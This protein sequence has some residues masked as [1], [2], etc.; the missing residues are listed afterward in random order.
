MYPGAD[1][2]QRLSPVR[3][4]TEELSTRR[5]QTCGRL[6]CWYA[7]ACFDARPYLILSLSFSLQMYEVWSKGKRPYF[8]LP[9]LTGPKTLLQCLEAG[10][11]V[12]LDPTCPMIIRQ[13]ITMCHAYEPRE[14]P[15]MTWLR[16]T[17]RHLETNLDLLDVPET[18]NCLPG[19]GTLT[20]TT[21]HPY[22]ELARNVSG[23]P[24]LL[25]ELVAQGQAQPVR[26]RPPR[27]VLTAADPSTQPRS[28]LRTQSLLSPFS[29]LA[30]MFPPATPTGSLLLSPNPYANP[31]AEVFDDMPSGYP[32]V[33]A[34]TVSTS[35]SRLQLFFDASV[36]TRPMKPLPATSPKSTSSSDDIIEYDLADWSLSNNPSVSDDLSQASSIAIL[37]LSGA[38]SETSSSNASRASSPVVFA[39]PLSQPRPRIPAPSAQAVHGLRAK[40][41]SVKRTSIV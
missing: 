31:Y 30:R 36:L 2:H 33:P 5:A 24:P 8:H 32:P 18:V 22:V 19:P 23:V 25:S 10:D 20:P 4:T 26:S 34:H 3:L 11:R 17:L 15:T 7:H 16:D 38:S 6:A 27:L 29:E 14:R 35:S 13:L 1:W 9:G 28:P 40:L 39:E 21:D 37:D 12:R 41:A